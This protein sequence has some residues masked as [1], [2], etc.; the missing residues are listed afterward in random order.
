MTV[1][2]SL[3][4]VD[5]SILQVIPSP[6]SPIP[7][8]GSVPFPLEVSEIPVRIAPCL[9][10]FD[11]ILSDRAEVMDQHGAGHAKGISGLP[12]PPEEIC[13]FEPSVGKPLVKQPDAV[14][15]RSPHQHAGP[16]DPWPGGACAAA[17]KFLRI[18]AEI[19][20]QRPLSG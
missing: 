19:I 2:K 15:H 8:R 20:V 12:G 14:E 3:V 13:I 11:S 4:A 16:V 17:D 18:A 5:P 7:S 1:A 10:P 9:C 6:L